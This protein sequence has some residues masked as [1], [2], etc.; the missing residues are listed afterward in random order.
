M[1]IEKINENQV[2]FTLTREDL[3]QR[4][5]KLSELAYGSEKAKS[6]FRDMMEQAMD[7][8][9]FDA[10]NTPLMIEAI[11]VSADSI[12]LIVTKVEDPE[13]LDSRFARFSRE[14]GA[15]GATSQLSVS[16]ADDILDLISKLSQ[17]RKAAAA[18]KKEDQDAKSGKSSDTSEGAPVPNSDS[19][20]GTID[21]SDPLSDRMTK[22]AVDEKDK[23]EVFHLTRFYLFHDLQTII[24]AAQVASAEYEGPS[25][26][27]KNPDDGNYYLLLRK[28][29]TDPKLFN[30]VCN[31]LSEYALPVDY[32]AGMEQ[33]FAEHF[34]VILDGNAMT[35]LRKL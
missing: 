18:K 16:G 12:V 13:E 30:R 20:T 25:S 2:R 27:F 21:G 17:S 1:K 35:S 31:T 11:P 24:R 8:T 6:L 15:P 7:E 19:T 22:I 32:Q 26:L 33:F 34:Q 5:I 9:G 10:G 29:D 4:Q 28:A 14:D 23:D 3:A